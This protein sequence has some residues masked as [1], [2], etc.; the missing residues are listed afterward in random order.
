MSIHKRRGISRSTI[1][2]W[3]NEHNYNHKFKG[4]FVNWKDYNDL[5][6]KNE[7]SQTIIKIL[8]SA[9]YLATDSINYKYTDIKGMLLDGY[10]I[11]VLCE[12]L[13]F[14]KG[15][16]QQQTSWQKQAKQRHDELKSIIEEIYH[17]AIRFMV[18]AKCLQLC[19]T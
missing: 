9:S 12:A 17:K 14:S 3:I 16:L 10:N 7:R 4:H 2:G 5:R 11:N 8:R 13:C 19:M 1:Y 15:T 18:P 6:R